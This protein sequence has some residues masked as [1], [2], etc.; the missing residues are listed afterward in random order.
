MIGG[1]SKKVYLVMPPKHQVYSENRTMSA[2][3]II[4]YVRADLLITP[5]QPL[6]ADW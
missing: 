2:D 5:N 1:V 4:N 3:Q 6:R